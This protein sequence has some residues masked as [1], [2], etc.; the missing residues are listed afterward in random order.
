MEEPLVKTL[1]RNGYRTKKDLVFIQSFEVAN[2]KDLN[3]MTKVR[4]A[5]LINNGGKPYDFVASGDARA[6]ADLITPAG[7][8]EIATYADGIGANKGLIIPRNNTND[9]LPPTTLIS[10]AHA[11]GLQVHAW[12]FRAEN[13]FLPAEYQTGADPT[14]LGDMEA[15]LHDFFAL[16]IDGVFS[17]HPDKAIEARNIFFD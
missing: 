17:D 10:D 13:F 6:Y 5:Q 15:E 11:A 14:A 2:L 8:A 1:H 3:R 12:T 4:I 9:Q 16:G 7:L